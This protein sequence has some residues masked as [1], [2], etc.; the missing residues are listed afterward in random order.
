MAPLIEQHRDALIALCRKHGLRRLEVFGSAARDDFDERRS[1]VDFLYELDPASPGSV[2]DRFWGFS[3]DA[4]FLLGR[5]VDM[6]DPTGVRNRFLLEA[7]NEDRTVI[8]ASR[9]Q[10]AA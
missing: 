8:F 9:D 6:V 2:W 3:E 1:D 10:K 5:R 7:I 4:Q